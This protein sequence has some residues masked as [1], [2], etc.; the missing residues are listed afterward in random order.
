MNLEQALLV[1]GNAHDNELPVAALDVAKTNWSAFYAELEQIIDQFVADDSSL[2]DEQNA[3]LFFGTLLLAELKYSPAL[4]KCLQ[5]FSCSDSFLTPIEGVFGDAITELTSTL[6]YNVAN[7]NTQALSDYI[8]AGHQAMYGKAS[9]ME[10]VFAQYEVGTIDKAEL[11]EHITLWLAAFL[12]L[13]SSISSFL[14]SALADSCIEYQLDDL[15]SQFIGLCDKD[16]FDEYR[17]KQDEVKAWQSLD[18]RK[19]IESGIIQ[20]EF[21]LVDTLNSWA[22]GDGSDDEV[23][24]NPSIDS[25]SSDN[26]SN[27]DLDVFDSLMGEGGL[28]SNILYDENTILENSVPVSS[29]ATAGR[30]DLCPCG[31]NKKYKKC[32]LQ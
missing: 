6:F 30:N 20:T 14:M 5:L 27:D 11:S 25:L 32:C 22:E 18:G 7:G 29:L 23:F 26:L 24:D 16:V 31:S 1:I 17:F 8:V 2:T 3:V 4:S 10:A 15:K 28:L 12:A 9:A 21:N 19:L 13:P